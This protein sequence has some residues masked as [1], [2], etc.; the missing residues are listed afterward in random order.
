[1]SLVAAQVNKDW[2]TEHALVRLGSRVNKP[3][4]SIAL[5]AP[6]FDTEALGCGGIPRGRIIEI[7]GPESSGKTTLA[8][9]IVAEA[10]KMNEL[11]AYIDI[12]HAL[13]A[14]YASKLGVDVDNLIVSQPDYGE[15]ALGIAESLV[16]SGLVSVIVID[17]VAALV[18]KAELEGEMGQNHMGLQ[19]RLLSQGCRKLCGV[20][21]KS[22]TILI[23]INQIR[24]KIGVMFGSP[25][26]TS[27]GRA[28]KF[29]SS[30][31]I[32]VRRI[33]DIKDGDKIIGH[34]MKLKI[35]KNKVGTPKKEAVLGLYY[36]GESEIVGFNKSG[37]LIDYA[38]G[39]ELVEKSGAWYSYKGERI[40]QGRM[41]A[42]VFLNENPEY[43]EK[44]LKASIDKALQLR[45]KQ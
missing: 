24:E 1:M 11:A 38:V 37:D 6:T 31:R 23:F 30:V 15:M 3:I 43:R 33:A 2:T 18:P 27:G 17:S 32:D 10:Q 19:A 16:Y 14:T 42:S 21:E 36:P 25:E 4:P 13:D 40:G 9:A 5:G 8:L 22:G 28:L 29:Y 44:I 35:V 34:D 7:F 41:N 20:A 39:L 26:T 45:G 12:E